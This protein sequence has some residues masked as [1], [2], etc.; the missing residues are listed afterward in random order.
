MFGWPARAR[1]AQTQALVKGNTSFALGLYGQLRKREGNLFFSPYSISTCLAIAYAGA[2]G[3]TQEQMS[4]ALHFDP[5]QQSFHPAFGELQAQLNQVAQQKGIELSI[6][7]ALWAQQGRPFAPA[8]L[9]TAQSQYQANVNQVDFRTGA[10]AARGQINR[11]VAERTKD[12]IQDLLPP[13]SVDASTRMVLANAIYFKGLWAHQFDKSETSNQP[14]LP[15][16]TRQVDAPFMHQTEQVAYMEDNDLQAVELSYGTNELS[17]VILLPRQVDG[18]AQLESRLNPALLSESISRLRK[19]KVELFLPR[20]KLE[21][22]LNLKDALAAMGMTDAFGSK[23]DFSGLD[24]TRQLFI[25][26]VFHKA[27]CEVTE[28]GTEAAAATGATI[29]LLSVQ[30]PPPTPVFRADHPFIFLIRH[31]ASGSILFLGRL[32]D[33]KS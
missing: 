21:S 24:G 2:R 33:P 10:D 13:G 31:P 28:E 11:W 8:F 26:G 18:C 22:G 7:N 12:K 14:F 5:D 32:S 4:L 1:A 19:Q 16:T 3:D 30:K 27:W 29:A 23:A 6:A 20:F 25:S 17:M 15:T 9:D